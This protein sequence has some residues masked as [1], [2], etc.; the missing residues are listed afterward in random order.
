MRLVRIKLHISLQ[1]NNTKESF[2][3]ISYL[4]LSSV[5]YDLLIHLELMCMKI[6]IE[7][8]PLQRPNIILSFCAFFHGAW[9]NSWHF[10]ARFFSTVSISK[11]KPFLCLKPLRNDLES[12]PKVNAYKIMI[13]FIFHTQI[14]VPLATT[15]SLLLLLLLFVTY[16]DSSCEFRSTQDKRHAECILYSSNCI[17]SFM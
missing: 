12:N 9:T 2:D 1:D 14:G 10:E 17:F 15:Y 16:S 6:L 3:P 8:M 7:L 4:H 11:L 13:Y 5:F